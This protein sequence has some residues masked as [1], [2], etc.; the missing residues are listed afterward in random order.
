LK[1]Q[2]NKGGPGEKPHD[3]RP[4]EKRANA[5]RDQVERERKEYRKQQEAERKRQ[6]QEKK[7]REQQE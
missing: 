2:K 5:F 7:R 3:D 1:T 4:E 6:K